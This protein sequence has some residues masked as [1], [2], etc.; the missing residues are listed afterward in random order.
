MSL[1]MDSLV[2][3]DGVSGRVVLVERLA[4]SKKRT[5]RSQQVHPGTEGCAKEISSFARLG[6]EDVIYPSSSRQ[7]RSVSAGAAGC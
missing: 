5:L 4:T 6:S 3:S 7:D 1:T 2:A